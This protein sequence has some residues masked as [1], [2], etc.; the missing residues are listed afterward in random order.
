[1]PMICGAAIAE[2][3]IDIRDGLDDL[4]RLHG[5]AAPR[6]GI[7]GGFEQ[8][9]GG[10]LLGHGGQ[11]FGDHAVGFADIDH[12]AV[13]QPQDAVADR[14]DVADGVRDEQDGDAA[15]A[16]F[17]DLAHAALAE[18]NVA[19]RQG[20]VHQQDFGIHVDG[21]REGQAHHHAARVGL[22]GLIDEVADLGEGGD[23]LVALVD[24]ARG[25][26]EDGAVQIDV[27]AAAEF[28]VESGAEF[29]QRGD[30]AVNTD[31]AGSGMQDPGHHLQ[32]R[33][34]AGAV[35][36]DD[37]EGLAALDLEAD[38]VERP[39]ILVALQTIQGQQ[40]LEAVA[41]RV[42]DRVAFRNTLEFNGVHGWEIER[43]V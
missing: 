36:P 18:V 32:E 7:G 1:M 8:Q 23:V 26:P 35:L 42:V 41:R 29:E 3:V 6:L 24:L 17:V 20:F 28:G 14:L 37:A 11:V 22:D 16:E 12:A 34:L 5:P 25:E 38:V 31:R 30:A 19:D 2:A 33:A 43:L 39:E 9:V 4:G 10:I 27:V 21:H 15:L 40:L 13:I